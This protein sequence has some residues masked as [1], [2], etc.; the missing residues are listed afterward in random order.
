LLKYLGTINGHNWLRYTQI[1]QGL[2]YRSPKLIIIRLILP[3]EGNGF[4][5]IVFFEQF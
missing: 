1:A 4:G 2:V 3:R 5:I